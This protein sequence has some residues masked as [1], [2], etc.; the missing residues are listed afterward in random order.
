MG[1]FIY[2]F[3]F[4][5]FR[6]PPVAYGGSQAKGLIR[7]VGASLCHSHSNRQ[8]WA[9]SATYT[10]VDGNA[11]SLTHWVGPGIKPATSRFLVRFISAVP[12][13]ELPNTCILYSTAYHP[14]I[15]I[16]LMIRLSQIWRVGGYP[17]KLTPVSFLTCSHNFFSIFLHF[18]LFIFFS[19]FPDSVLE[20]AISPRKPDLF[21]WKMVFIFQEHSLL[22]WC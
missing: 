17:F 16:I 7:A 12:W 18:E 8:M 19:I 11:G 1:A 21:Q 4:G 2:L 14:I 3:I 10:T 15:I 9:K 13:W 22:L 5:I 6:V 20:W